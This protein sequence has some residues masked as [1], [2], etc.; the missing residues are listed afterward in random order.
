MV[1]S[2]PLVRCSD[3]GS[4]NLVRDEKH[5]ELVCDDCGL[6]L[7]E[8][9]IEETSYIKIDEQLLKQTNQRSPLNAHGKRIMRISGMKSMREKE[10]NSTAESEARDYIK[11]YYGNHRNT[12]EIAEEVIWIFEMA[13]KEQ[14]KKIVRDT[15]ARKMMPFM[16]S[17]LTNNL[18][19]VCAVH[20]CRLYLTRQ[21]TGRWT[22]GLNAE[23]NVMIKVLP[24]SIFP[25]AAAVGKKELKK[26]LLKTFR[27][28]KQL[29]PPGTY[30]G[31]HGKIPIKK[32]NQSLNEVF[33]TGIELLCSSG[34]VPRTKSNLWHTAEL[35]YKKQ[36]EVPLGHA[37]WTLFGEF[38]YQLLKEGDSRVP[39]RLIIEALHPH[40]GPDDRTEQWREHATIMANMVIAIVNSEDEMNNQEGD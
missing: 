2:H 13:L 28:L 15:N 23:V 18:S 17:G 35:E 25:A 1:S 3:C 38:A 30:S 39:R 31:I 26:K 5:G 34:L 37:M 19:P 27:F 22:E 24:D 6:V 12:G 10:Y 20:A 33:D 21:R 11:W 14:R 4:R 40:L 7:D 8:I 29:L 36:E 32:Y 9:V 16:P